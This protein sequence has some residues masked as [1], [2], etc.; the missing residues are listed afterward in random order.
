LRNIASTIPRYSRW[1]II[2]GA[3]TSDRNLT[4]E[5]PGLYAIASGF[6]ALSPE[7]FAD[8]HTLL[9]VEFP[10]YD[11]LYAYCRGTTASR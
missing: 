4:A 10:M 9:D 2:R 1:R 7:Q 3:D 5:S 8:D 11:A 6:A